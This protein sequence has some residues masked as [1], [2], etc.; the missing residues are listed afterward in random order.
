GTE[1]ADDAEAENADGRD[2]SIDAGEER[3]DA[4]SETASM[5]EPTV[6]EEKPS[7]RGWFGLR[8]GRR[9][10]T[11]RRGGEVPGLFEGQ[12]VKATKASGTSE[13]EPVLEPTTSP[14]ET[15]LSQVE[16]PSH[17]AGTTE[18]PAPERTEPTSRDGA[19][20]KSSADTDGDSVPQ[21][22]VSDLA[23][24]SEAGAIARYLSHRYKGVGEKTAESLVEALGADLF[25]TMHEDPDAIA[26][27]VPKNRAEQVL[28]AWRADYERRAASHMGRSGGDSSGGGRGRS[29]GRGR[30]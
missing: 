7:D 11:R 25:R 17:T 13:P 5:E 4:V 8:F 6:V 21:V 19:A 28:E 2:T 9:S 23:L 18:V 1:E 24:P 16:T 27:I 12:G 22:P 10:T 29:R 15:A 3:V 30:G 26:K 20:E 14:R